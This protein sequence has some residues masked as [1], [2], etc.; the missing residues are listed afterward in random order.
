MTNLKS[1]I[2]SLIATYAV[3]LFAFACGCLVFFVEFM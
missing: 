2:I 1:K 3:V